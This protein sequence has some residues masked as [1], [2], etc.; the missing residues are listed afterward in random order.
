[1]SSMDGPQYI[2]N[3]VRVVNFQIMVQFQKNGGRTTTLKFWIQVSWSST[4]FFPV[5][6]WIEFWI[7]LRI[8]VGIF[9]DDLWQTGNSERRHT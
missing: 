8:G 4:I 2:E 1:M 9:L 3:E 6:F 7:L 5:P